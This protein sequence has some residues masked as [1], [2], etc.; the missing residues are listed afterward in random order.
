MSV[1]HQRVFVAALRVAA[2]GLVAG[3]AK[4]V[5]P[6]SPPPVAPVEEVKPPP[7]KPD[8]DDGLALEGTLGTIADDDIAQAFRTRWAEVTKCSHA[9]QARL[10]YVTGT[11]QLK[12]RVGPDG[13][14][15]KAYVE[16]SSLGNYEAERCVL[17]VARAIVFPKPQGGAEA[18]FTFPIEVR[19]RASSPWVVAWEEARIAPSVQR[20]KKDIGLCRGEALPQ[21]AK[22]R[23]HLAQRAKATRGPLKDLPANLAL[24]LYIGPGGKVSSMGF[25]A[26][27]PLDEAF[28]SCLYDRSKTWKLD[29]PRSQIAKATIGVSP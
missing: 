2:F 13:V 3:C 14:P 6:P 22:G 28:A 4:H 27:G 5:P 15:K 9:A 8:H 29:D 23:R 11:V 19:P 7:P 24:T 18:E 12:L 17:D 21:H 26:E 16:R 25:A 20:S 1:R 10:S